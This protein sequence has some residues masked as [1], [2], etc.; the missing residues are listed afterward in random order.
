VKGKRKKNNSMENNVCKYL[1]LSFIA[2]HA[3]WTAYEKENTLYERVFDN[4]DI[5]CHERMGHKES[6]Q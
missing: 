2:Y 3:F 5:R 6:I 1:W 4:W